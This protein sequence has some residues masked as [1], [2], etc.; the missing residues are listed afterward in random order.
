MTPL[1][2]QFGLKKREITQKEIAL[3]L[4][5]SEMAVSLVINK[6]T[7]SD[8]IMKAVSK[9][10]KMDHRAVFPEYYFKL[11]SRKRAA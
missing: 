6:M 4:S 7:V 3:D 5:V 9:A 1:E 10:I 8:R 2:I 11:K